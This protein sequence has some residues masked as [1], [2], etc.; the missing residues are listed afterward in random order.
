MVSRVLGYARDFLIARIFGASLADRRLLRRLQASPTCCAACSPRAP[1][2]RPSCRSWRSTRT[3]TA[4]RQTRALIDR[5]RDAC[6]SSRL[7]VTAAARHGGRA[8][9]RLRSRRR[10]SAADPAEVRA[11]GADAAHHLPYIAFI[12]LVAL[13]A[14]IL[15][16]WNRFSVPAITPA[17]LNVVVHRRRAVLRRPLRP[18]GAGAR[19]GGVRRRRRCSSP[20]RCRSS[21]RLGLLPRWRLDFRIPGV[22]RVLTLMVP[23]AFGVSVSQVSLLDQHRSSPRSCVTGSVSW[24]YYADRLMELPAGVLGVALGTI[25]LPSLSKYHADAEP[26]R[27]RAPARLGAARDGAARACRAAVALAVLAH[28]AGRDAVPLRPLHRGTTPG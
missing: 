21:R 19:L 20:S 9:D 25:L 5:V 8:A 6:C 14:G 3:E 2:R 22:R 4:S 1:S 16:T 7:V 10:A 26:G 27:V 24:L 13:A 12:S 28:A 18:A 11:H 17:L 23:A 15:N